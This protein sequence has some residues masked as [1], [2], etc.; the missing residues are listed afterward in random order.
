MKE[1]ANDGWDQLPS[2]LKDDMLIRVFRELSIV[3]DNTRLLILVTNGFLELLVNRLIET[4][5]KNAKKISSN[6]QSFPYATKLLILNEIGIISD[7]DYKVFEWFRKLRNKSAHL[8]V[9]EVTKNELKQL[10]DQQYH[11]PA[12]FYNLC[13][14]FIGGFWNGHIEV[15]G[16][17]F[18]PGATGNTKK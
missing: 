4:K 5:T 7:D 12:N 17:V 8:P 2:E 13:T 3:K 11:D 9:F 1:Q 6:G 10:S 15:F 18:A 14:I 16:P